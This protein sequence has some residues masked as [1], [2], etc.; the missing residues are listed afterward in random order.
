M[1]DSRDSE[2]WTYGEKTEAIA[3]NY[4]N[5][6]Y[7]LM[8][9]YY[10]LFKELEE[11][12]LPVQRSLVLTDPWA[13]Q[14]YAAAYQNQFMIGEFLLVAP[15]SAYQDFGQVFLPKRGNDSWY[16]LYTDAEVP[17]GEPIT[18]AQLEYLPVFVQAG[19]IIPMRSVVQHEG[20]ADDGVLTVHVYKGSA[21][22]VF[23]FYWDAGDGFAYQAGGYHRRTIRQDPEKKALVFQEA[24]GDLALPWQRLRVVLHGFASLGQVHVSGKSVPVKATAF[25]FLDPLP[26][27]DPFGNDSSE[28]SCAVQALD[29][30]YAS[31]AIEI[32]Y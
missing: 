10:S 28:Y 13:D 1:I 29:I 23:D 22:S 15:V 9:Y 3:R 18:K 4:I 6:R 21:P 27:F 32:L 25:S 20:D 8:P 26:D 31:E 17:A 5:L 14:T 19:A 16:Y 24:A 2:P 30:P 12:S 11:K 7:Q